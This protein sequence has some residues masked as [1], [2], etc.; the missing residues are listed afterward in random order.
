MEGK[1]QES[2]RPFTVWQVTVAC[3]LG[4]PLA[5]SWLMARNYS[6]WGEKSKSLATLGLGLLG[7]LALVGV[8]ALIPTRASEGWLPLSA[9]VTMKY[10]AE[11]LQ[12]ASVAKHRSNGGAIASWWN[13]FGVGIAGLLLVSAI[14]LGVVFATNK[15]PKVDGPY[16]VSSAAVPTVFEKLEKKKGEGSFAAFI[17]FADGKQTDQNA[18]NL[19]FSFENGRVGL[20]W[21][22]R[23]PINIRDKDRFKT[24]AEKLGYNVEAKEQ[25]GVRYLRV[26]RGGDLRELCRRILYELY[27]VPSDGEIGLMLSGIKW[28]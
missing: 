10:L 20:D 15:E 7:T 1:A 8:G 16:V 9:M 27:G 3:A 28:P 17:F 13:A 11:H 14:V 26:E 2:L 25:N 23:A 6:N 12:G 22:L 4:S 24:F 21:V 5:G 19:Q 18:V